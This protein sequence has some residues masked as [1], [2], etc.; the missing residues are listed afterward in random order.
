MK[1]KKDFCSGSFRRGAKGAYQIGA[2][3]ALDNEGYKFSAV[4][5]ASVGSLNAAL[6]AQGDIERA[7]H[8]WEEIEI[9]NV[10][11]V[12][13]DLISNGKISLNTRSLKSLTGTW[14]NGLLLDS[15]PLKKLIKKRKLMKSISEK[16]AWTLD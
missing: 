13:P 8:L 9:L 11:D 6:V 1:Y 16:E 15:S 2:W 5:G 7:D 12:P 10:V 14:Q 3:K 4:T